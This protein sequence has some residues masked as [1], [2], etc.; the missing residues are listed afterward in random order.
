[1]RYYL[2]LKIDRRLFGVVGVPSM[3][4]IRARSINSIIGLDVTPSSKPTKLLAHPLRRQLS[5]SVADLSYFS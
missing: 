1:M 4:D 2:Y 5:A 3:V